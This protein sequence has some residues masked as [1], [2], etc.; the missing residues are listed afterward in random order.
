MAQVGYVM[1]GTNDPTRAVAF[2]DAILKPGSL[3]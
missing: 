3:G 2:H 1:L